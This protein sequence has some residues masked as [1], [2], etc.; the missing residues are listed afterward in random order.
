MLSIIVPIYNSQKYLLRFFEYIH[1][2]FSKEGIEYEIV[3]VDDCSTDSSWQIIRTLHSVHPGIIKGIQLS[4]NFGQHMAIFQG[5]AY[6]SGNVVITSDVVLHVPQE[7]LIELYNLLLTSESDFTY[8][9]FQRHY[10]DFV[11]NAMSNAFNLVYHGIVGVSSNGSNYRALKKDTFNRLLQYNFDYG[12]IDTFL[13]LNARGLA[14]STVHL[15]GLFKDSG[16]TYMK[17]INQAMRVLF[18]SLIRRIWGFNYTKGNSS[19]SIVSRC[20]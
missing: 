11:L 9:S 3:F 20:L 13:F 16:Y 8:L 7:K 2:L 6:V 10:P 5:F 17:K 18:M 14:V 1:A 19:Q 4:S 12:F 15:P